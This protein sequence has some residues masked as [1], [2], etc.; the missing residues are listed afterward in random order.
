MKLRK[1]KVIIREVIEHTIDIEE[2]N[3]YMAKEKA[4]K[5]V[6]ARLLDRIWC[7]ITDIA[8]EEHSEKE[9]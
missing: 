1:F 4:R 6:E 3:E 7:N 5:I 9:A 2:L 8:I